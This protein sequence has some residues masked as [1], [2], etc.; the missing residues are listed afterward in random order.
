MALAHSG[1]QGG[2]EPAAFHAERVMV[3]QPD[4]GT[5][6]NTLTGAFASTFSVLSAW[7]A[8]A[9]GGMVAVVGQSHHGRITPRDLRLKRQLQP[10]QTSP[11]ARQ[12][13]RVVMLA[14]FQTARHGSRRNTQS[15][16]YIIKRKGLLDR[17]PEV[18]KFLTAGRFDI[19]SDLKTAGAALGAGCAVIVNSLLVS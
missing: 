11:G 16:A 5:A 12:G 7:C 10:V 2:R 13:K 6:L 19:L 3:S 18:S 17:P 4:F 1:R 9:G 14:S 8:R 15:L